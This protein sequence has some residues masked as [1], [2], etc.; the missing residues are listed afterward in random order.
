MKE[1]ERLCKKYNVLFICDEVQAGFGRTGT[2]FG[3]EHE[4]VKPDMVCLGKSLSGGFMPVSA[5]LGTNEVMNQIQPGEHGSTFGGNPLASRT[6]IAA[7]DVVIDEKLPQNAERMGNLLL[8]NFRQIFSSSGRNGKHV[9]EIRGVGLFMAI[10]FHNDTLAN[11]LS[12][13]LL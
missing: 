9:K 6:A 13:K 12:K 3:F 8:N 4:G 7:I 2:M 11:S 5:V 1:V 10:E